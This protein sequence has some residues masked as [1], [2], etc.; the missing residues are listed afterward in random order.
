MSHHTL[1]YRGYQITIDVDGGAK[2]QYTWSYTI[3][4]AGYTKCQDRS[5]TSEGVMLAEGTFHAKQKIDAYLKATEH[6][7]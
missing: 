5:L 1:E 3:D 7:K 2:G 6:G 4:G